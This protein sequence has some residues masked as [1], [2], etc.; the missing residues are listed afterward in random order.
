MRF[1]ETL[2]SADRHPISIAALKA[3]Y[4]LTLTNRYSL[5]YAA[6]ASLTFGGII[7][8]V[9]SAQQIFVDEFGAGS[10]FTILFEVIQ[11]IRNNRGFE[12]CLS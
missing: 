1:P 12:L 3:S 11:S 2:A 5:G 4:R 10:R 7:A 9:S 8:F 6:A